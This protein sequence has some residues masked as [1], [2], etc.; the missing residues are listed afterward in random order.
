MW[1]SWPHA[2]ITGTVTP[3]RFFTMDVL[4]NG[5]PVFSATGSASSSVR[6]ITVGPP[7][8]LP[9]VSL[10]KFVGR[11]LSD[12]GRVPSDVGRVLL[13]PAWIATVGAVALSACQ[14]APKPAEETPAAAVGFAAVANQ[15]GGQDQ[16][17]PY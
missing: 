17:G 8:Q 1:R 6:S 13:D 16:T 15:K 12:V 3:A 7:P 2:C 4:A 14:A 9:S 5:T 10:S 11:V